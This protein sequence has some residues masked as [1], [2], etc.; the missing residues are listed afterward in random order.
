MADVDDGSVVEL[1]G[2]VEPMQVAAHAHQR[3]R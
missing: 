2:Q 1:H 3:E